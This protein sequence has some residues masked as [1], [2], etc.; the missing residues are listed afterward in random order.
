M[1]RNVT[2]MQVRKRIQEHRSVDTRFD[3]LSAL[4]TSFDSDALEAAVSPSFSQTWPSSSRSAFSW[5]LNHS[6]P[7]VSFASLFTPAAGRV[8]LRQSKITPSNNSRNASEKPVNDSAQ[9]LA[10]IV[11]SSSIPLFPCSH[12]HSFPSFLTVFCRILQH[13]RV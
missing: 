1:P 12:T 6:K 11:N 2:E 4:G 3:A 8:Y 13:C 5:I 10:A 7:P 9:V